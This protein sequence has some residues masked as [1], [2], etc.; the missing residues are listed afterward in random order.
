MVEIREID[1]DGWRAIR[2]IR[3]AALQDAPDAF[4]STY[5]REIAFVEADWLRRISSGGNFLAYAP[6]LG[7]APVGIAGGSEAGMARSLDPH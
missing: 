4:A 6:E 3:L 5:A 1:A 2:D 7:T